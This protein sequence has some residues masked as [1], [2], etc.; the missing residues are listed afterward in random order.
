MK[1]IKIFESFDVSNQSF[2]GMIELPEGYGLAIFGTDE[3]SL[4]KEY[5]STTT[6]G[7]D[8]S[9]HEEAYGSFEA[10]KEDLNRMGEIEYPS[11]SGRFFYRG[12]IEWKKM[13]IDYIY[14]LHP[15]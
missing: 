14:E 7:M 4:M 9:Y 10:W 11:G 5:S 6:P 8:Y 3:E 13:G 2:D 15:M 1:H 12:K